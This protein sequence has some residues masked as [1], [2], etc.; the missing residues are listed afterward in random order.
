MAVQIYVGN[1]TYGLREETLQ[2]L[3]EQYGEVSAVKIVKDRMTGRS[4]GFAFVEM[5]ETEEA[6]KAIEKLNGSE[7]EGRTIKV[8]EARPRRE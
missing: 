4:R 1:I 6:K 7:L 3:F 8:D 5:P 2:E